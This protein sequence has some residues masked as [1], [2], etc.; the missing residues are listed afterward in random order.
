[1]DLH[2]IN[3]TPGLLKRYTFSADFNHDGPFFNNLLKK[4]GSGCNMNHPG[5]V[6]DATTNV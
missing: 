4:S 2:S 5:G 1:M 6:K 3:K